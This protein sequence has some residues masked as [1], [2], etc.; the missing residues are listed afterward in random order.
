MLTQLSLYAVELAL[1][2]PMLSAVEVTTAIVAKREMTRSGSWGLY[3][4]AVELLAILL[5]LMIPALTHRFMSGA[6]SGDFDTQSSVLRNMKKL[7]TFRK[8]GVSQS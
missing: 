2:F 4:V 8:A 7:I 1:W 6:F 3:I 5:I